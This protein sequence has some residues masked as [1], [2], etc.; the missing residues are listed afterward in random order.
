MHLSLKKTKID[1]DDDYFISTD[2]IPTDRLTVLTTDA[3]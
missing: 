1:T 3:H 2:E